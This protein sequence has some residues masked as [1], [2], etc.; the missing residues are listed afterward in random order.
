M[1]FPGRTLQAG[2]GV[3]SDW[4]PRGGDNAVFRA[5]LVAAELSSGPVGDVDIRVF[6]KNSED[7]GNGDE[8]SAAAITMGNTAGSS[9][10]DIAEQLVIST[11][12]SSAS[13]GI[14]EMLRYKVEVTGGWMRVNVFPPVFFDSAI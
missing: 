13:T 14:M 12:G 2:E 5:Q 7:Q 6:T 1:E 10:G 8:I 4:F 9:V 11:H 3:F